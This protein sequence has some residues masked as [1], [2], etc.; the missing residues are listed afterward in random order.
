MRVQCQS[1]GRLITL[2]TK[3]G[4]GGEGTIS[5][6]L[7]EPSL[8]AKIY[9][10]HK[11]TKENSDKLAM[12][13]A[14]PPHDPAASQGHISIAWPIDL[15][16]ADGVS[17]QLIG[18]LMR[19]VTQVRPIHD[20]YTP[21]TRYQ[22]TP[23]FNYRYLHR[24]ARNLAAAV[25]A[26]HARGYVIGDVNESNILVAETALVTL[27]DTDSF[28]VRDLK[29]GVVYRCP[30][31]KPEFTPPELQGQTFR[32]IDRTPEHDLFGLAVLIFQLLMEGTH[33]FEGV[34]Q[35]SDEPSPKEKRIADGHFP[36]GNKQVPYNPKPLAPPFEILHPKLQ[37][38][39]VRC[40]ED[41]HKQPQVRPNAQTWVKALNEA[42]NELVS[43]WVNDQHRYGGHLSNCPWCERAALLGGRDPFPHSSYG[44]TLQPMVS[45]PTLA[46]SP[47]TIITL[48]APMYINKL[49]ATGAIL[50]LAFTG[51]W[52]WQF[53]PVKSSVSSGTNRSTSI[54]TNSKPQPKRAPETSL[55]NF[56]LTNTLEG[57]TNEVTAV[58]FSPDGKTLASSSR[59]KTIK[60]WNIA[61]G[62]EIGT[63]NGHV[64][65]VNAIAFSPDGETLASGSYDGTIKFWDFSNQQELRSLKGHSM[66]VNAIAFSPDGGTLASIS[67][68]GTIK[69]WNLSI[70]TDERTL[71]GHSTLV[72]SV[73]FSPNGETLA[74]GSGDNT[75]KLWDL[76]TGRDEGTLKGHSGWVYTVAFSPDGKTLASG[77]WDNT[78][79]LWNLKE[80]NLFRTL[81]GHSNEVYSVA[82][83]PDGKTLASASRDNTIKLWEISTGKD[84]GTLKGHSNEV[85]SVAFSPNRKTLASGSKD[86]TIKIW[87]IS[88]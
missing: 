66:Q 6:V 27:V 43:C 61:R 2:D 14:N 32:D 28:Q 44:Q 54:P 41:G 12:M 70:E 1:N 83:S 67:Y 17:Q 49:L 24:T 34:F 13:F 23:L 86:N 57:H 31:G 71:K 68:D 22:Y 47:Q 52:Y 63:L 88:P 19:R 20:F 87:R 16:H 80:E 7:E 64:N 42:E 58:A 78:I 76:S 65:E 18:F 10:P 38:L 29:K 33:P 75:I 79:K 69:L 84:L 21:K 35:G 37:Q 25:G 74:S 39:F 56:S 36:Y 72:N 81:S 73:A 60:L 59:D 85:V 3:L 8:V 45:Q 55:L 9:H 77:S 46:R 5:S 48:L 26:L 62:E 82:F 11:L 30:V 53:Y 40:F 51:Y 15:L 50:L 4:S